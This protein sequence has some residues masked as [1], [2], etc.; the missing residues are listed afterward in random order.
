MSL[1]DLLE[2]ER[3]LGQLIEALGQTGTLPQTS[4]LTQTGSPPRTL[5]WQMDALRREALASVDLD[6]TKTTFEDLAVAE[7][8]PGLLPEARRASASAPLRLIRCAQTLMQR[9]VSGREAPDLTDWPEDDTENALE[10]LADLAEGEPVPDEKIADVLA[11]SRQAIASIDDFLSGA[12][13]KK[14]RAMVPALTISTPPALSRPW[15]IEAWQRLTGASGTE[16]STGDDLEKIIDEGL[17][18]PGLAGVA[19]VLHRLHR[20]DLFRVSQTS[21]VPDGLYMGSAL[22]AEIRRALILARARNEPM[23]PGWRFARFLAPWLIMRSCGGDAHSGGGAHCGG[24]ARTGP[25]ISPAIRRARLGYF[26]A[27]NA[28]EDE[29]AAWLYRA[30]ADGFAAERRRLRDLAQLVDR[31]QDRFGAVDRE[32]ADGGGRPGRKRRWTTSRQV[33]LL[34]VDHPVVTTKFLEYRR[35]ITRRAAQMLVKDLE[36][37]SILHRVHFAKGQ[38]WLI[39]NELIWD[40]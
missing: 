31:W 24:A 40:R 10:D 7:I 11:G 5:L 20:D 28:S 26:A 2:A 36:Q 17:Q 8:D 16:S 29:W 35:D 1:R 14:P 39:A 18:K 12:E 6:G 13:D 27:A 23:G 34:L 21:S 32:P 37:S 9:R 38:E 30:L 33:L 15:L 25:W 4:G 3:Q 22:P 19:A